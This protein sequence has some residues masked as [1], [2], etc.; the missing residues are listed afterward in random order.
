MI[1]PHQV[2]ITINSHIY[3]L[4]MGTFTFY[5]VVAFP[6]TQQ[7]LSERRYTQWLFSSLILSN[8][9]T[10]LEIQKHG[11]AGTKQRQP[12]FSLSLAYFSK[13]ILISLPIKQRKSKQN[14][15]HL[16]VCTYLYR[17]LPC[18]NLYKMQNVLHFVLFTCYQE[19]FQN[20]T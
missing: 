6:E 5:A 7:N 18:K 8:L 17:M 20:T 9:Y 10:W 11:K 2:N 1:F 15:M 16:P 3:H 14:N 4:C 19:Y 12:P 13:G